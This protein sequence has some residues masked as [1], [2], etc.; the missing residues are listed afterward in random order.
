MSE[1][2]ANAGKH[3]KKIT[4]V[5]V[6]KIRDFNPP[7]LQNQTASE[8]FFENFLKHFKQPGQYIWMDASPN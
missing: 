8:D 6:I 2:T 5:V 3:N 4:F 7:H 1:D